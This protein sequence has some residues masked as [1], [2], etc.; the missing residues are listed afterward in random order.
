M[1]KLLV[2][3][4]LLDRLMSFEAGELDEQNEKIVELFQNLVDTG[5]AWQL[6]GNYGRIASAMIREGFIR[7][8]K[9]INA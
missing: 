1:K 8:A 4:D 2:L 6:Q 7:P 5:F 3:P 9:R